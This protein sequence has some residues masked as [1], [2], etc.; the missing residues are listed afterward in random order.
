[1]T[2]YAIPRKDIGLEDCYFYHTME[3]PGIGPVKGEWHLENVMEKYLGGVLFAG[4]RVVEVGTASGFLCCQMEKNDA[5]VVAYDLNESHWADNLVSPEY[6]QAEYLERYRQFT[7]K[8]NNSFWLVHE[9][10][11]LAASMVYGSVYDMPA[12]MGDFEIATL[13]CV[14]LHLRDPF[15]ALQQTLART[16]ET[17][18]ITEYLWSWPCY[19]VLGLPGI[20]AR[21]A[22]KL[23]HSKIHPPGAFF[24]PS[25]NR[26][27][28]HHWWWLLL[29]DTVSRMISLLGFRTVKV[30]YHKQTHM[31]ARRLLYTLVGERVE[32]GYT[33]I[34]EIAKAHAAA[35]R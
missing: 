21:K 22:S 26:S 23:F 17:V 2:I 20:I 19:L 33:P 6:D 14:L 15:R 16:K 7:R 35:A 10:F 29:P 13:C 9:R 4:K 12:E 32:A 18:I 11:Q 3:I 31:D 1:M 25:N 30:I 28:Q 5:E 27:S 8:L 34:A 24:M